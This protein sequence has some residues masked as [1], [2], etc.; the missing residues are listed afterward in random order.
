[1]LLFFFVFEQYWLF[2]CKV[3]LLNVAFVTVTSN[4]IQVV[5]YSV[6]IIT[7]IDHP[8]KIDNSDFILSNRS[9]RTSSTCTE[10]EVG[11]GVG[12]GIGVGVIRTWS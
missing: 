12:D 8:M 11:A 4:E 5:W 10:S 9:M 6:E 1:M 7:H 2:H 3:L